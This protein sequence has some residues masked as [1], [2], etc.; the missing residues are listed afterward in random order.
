MRTFGKVLSLIAGLA[1]ASAT[2]A[3]ADGSRSW[4]VCGGDTFMTC[5]AVDVSVVGSQVTLRVWNLSGNG[6]A[7]NGTGYAAPAGT[8]LNGIGFY[9][10]AGLGVVTNSLSVGGPVRP[11]D[12]PTG[13]SLKNLGSVAFMV[14]FR[15]ATSKTDGGIAS[16][17]A[18]PGQ[19]PGTPPNL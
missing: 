10:T 8:I 5:A 14:D 3:H 4:R 18:T 6:M 12:N 7:T 17:C 13:W 15:S 11:G 16:A 9:N 2:A 1:L 19:L